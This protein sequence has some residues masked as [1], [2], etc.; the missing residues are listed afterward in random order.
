MKKPLNKTSAKLQLLLN[1]LSI[2]LIS[3][4]IAVDKL[5]PIS[6]FLGMV[7]VIAIKLA[8]DNVDGLWE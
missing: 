7:L 5:D 1:S 3:F 8:S 2:L 4:L 6:V